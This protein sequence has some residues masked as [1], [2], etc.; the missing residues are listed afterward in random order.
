MTLAPLGARAQSRIGKVWRIGWISGGRRP[1]KIETTVFGEFLKGMKDYGHAEGKHFSMEWRFAE[2]RFN[3]L[4]ELAAEL[5]KS[6]VDVIVASAAQAIRPLQQATTEIPI[7]MAGPPD[8]V[9]SGFVKSLARPGGNTTGQSS[10]AQD[11]IFKHIDILRRVVPSLNTVGM[12]TNPN[13]SFNENVLQSVYSNLIKAGQSAGMSIL[14]FPI[15]TPDRIASTFE[16]MKREGVQSV[17]VPGE[18]FTMSHSGYIARLSRLQGLPSICWFR[19]Y[20]QAGG[21]MSYGEGLGDLI[22][23]TAYYVDKLMKG[24]KPA[25]LP[26]QQPTRFYLVVNRRTA[27]LLKETISDELLTIADEVI[28]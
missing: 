19:E 12:I 5:V 7:V 13:T 25:D 11:M 28:E 27:S 16:L 15:G 24:A 14:S 9:G 17:I 10:A 3:L 20:V 1:E 23:R 22:R 18:P 8:P 26:I 2:T 4:P 21:L 6:R